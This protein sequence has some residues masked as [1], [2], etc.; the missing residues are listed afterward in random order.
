MRSFWVYMLRC[1]DG[2]YYIGHT[3]DLK[4]HITAS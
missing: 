1:R 4:T 2:S 3:D